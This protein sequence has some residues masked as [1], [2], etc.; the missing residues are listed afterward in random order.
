MSRAAHLELD[1]IG[2]ATFTRGGVSARHRS[3]T[4]LVPLTPQSLRPRIESIPSR[5][6]LVALELALVLALVLTTFAAAG[7]KESPRRP[8]LSLCHDRVRVVSVESATR[9]SHCRSL[10][11]L[12]IVSAAALD[13][14]GL[15]ELREVRGDIQIGPTTGLHSISGLDHLDV[16]GG[17]LRIDH[18][19][20]LSGVFWSGL[21]HVGG[22]LVIVANLSLHTISLPA[23]KTVGGSISV[24][25]N[26]A[27]ESVSL[28]A[29]V[30]VGGTV[31]VQKSSALFLLDLGEFKPLSG[32]PRS[33]ETLD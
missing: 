31:E 25:G 17:S 21:T 11:D 30:G 6:S 10:A 14:G 32:H 22:D 2:L 3:T 5:V 28:P 23:L 12:E 8:S 27:L 15:A 33:E 9:L 26:S 20:E 29:L 7:C 24:L 19:V 13:L 18:N 16:V 1:P 4:P